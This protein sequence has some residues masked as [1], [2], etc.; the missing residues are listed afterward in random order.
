MPRR[1]L[2]NLQTQSP[3]LHPRN[4]PQKQHIARIFF[5]ITQASRPRTKADLGSRNHQSRQRLKAREI[6]IM[7]MKTSCRECGKPTWAG[8]GRHIESALRG[9]PE[10]DRCPG[11]K[12]G[13]CPGKTESAYVPPP[14]EESDKKAKAH[15]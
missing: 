14:E 1:F 8:C 13:R 3:E 15:S 7:C 2:T 5:T 11:W 10:A 6:A 9:I 4:H 12:S